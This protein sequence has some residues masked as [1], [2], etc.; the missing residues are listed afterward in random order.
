MVA[1]QI[2]K[3]IGLVAIGLMILSDFILASSI[4]LIKENVNMG[5]DLS[6]GIH[7]FGFLLGAVWAG[8][9]ER[10]MRKRASMTFAIFGQIL[11]WLFILFAIRDWPMYDS[12]P[13]W[14]ASIVVIWSLALVLAKVKRV[15]KFKDVERRNFSYQARM[16]TLEN[17]NNKCAMCDDNLSSKIIEFDHID[18]DRS[19][20]DPSNCQALCSN[21]HSTKTRSNQV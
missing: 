9:I 2:R 12:R 8:A 17:Q 10:D 3:T 21:C 11:T 15:S 20:N 16:D 5:S 18:G 7:I 14:I 13:I 1:S 4:Y 6:L 19:N